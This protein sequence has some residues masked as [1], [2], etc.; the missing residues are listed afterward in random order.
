MYEQEVKLTAAN[1]A[2]LA[3]VLQSDTIR[4]L[5]TG[6]GARDSV[7]ST[8][9]YYDTAARQLEN[10]RC[11]LRARREEQNWRAT[12]KF[13]GRIENGLF[14][15][16]EME[17]EIG[18]WLDHAGQL[19]AGELRDQVIGIIPAEAPLI[20]RVTVVMQRSIRNLH[21]ADSEIEL[22]ADRA[23]ISKAKLQRRVDLYEIELELKRGDVAAVV[24]L[25]GLLTRQFA[26]TPSTL[27]KHRIGRQ[28]A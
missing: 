27:S 16:R 11:S 19:P 5:D 26:L 25:G 20:A 6:I 12:F 13:A 9:V 7:P 23:T 17:T 3:Q 21:F 22:S 28:L 8:G 14:S 4:R 1:E 24:Q 10:H 2:T 18:G 15:R